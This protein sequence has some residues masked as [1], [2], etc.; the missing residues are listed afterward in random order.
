MS[1]RTQGY[2]PQAGKPL[3]ERDVYTTKEVADICGMSQ[4]VILREF[5][6]GRLPGF[7]FPDGHRRV[8]RLGLLMFMTTHGI[9][10]EFLTKATEAT[11]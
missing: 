3:A 2:Q 6:A 11:T 1:K 10:E 5:D 7:R 9:P 4:H 8:T